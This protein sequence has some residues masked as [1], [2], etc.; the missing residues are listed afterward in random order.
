MPYRGEQREFEMSQGVTLTVNEVAKKLRIGRGTAY[1]AV[2]SGAIPSIRVGR[3][4]LVPAVALE[5]LL[6]RTAAS[7]KAG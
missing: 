2:K 4:I 1:E 6:D 5:R 3:R 7:P